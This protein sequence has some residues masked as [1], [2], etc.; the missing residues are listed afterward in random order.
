MSGPSM[1]VKE[2][3]ARKKEEYQPP[4]AVMSQR[5]EAEVKKEDT[6]DFFKKLR[7]KEYV[8]LMRE[9]LFMKG[10]QQFTEVV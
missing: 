4:Q 1:N 6:S 10:Q 7:L 9:M 5:K 2:A 3:P 8:R